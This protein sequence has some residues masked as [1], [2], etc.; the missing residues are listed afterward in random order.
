MAELSEGDGMLVVVLG[1]R[2]SD[3]GSDW[4]GELVV[5]SCREIGGEKGRVALG[6]GGFMCL[7]T[8]VTGHGT[9]SVK[10]LPES[11]GLFGTRQKWQPR[12]GNNMG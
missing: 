4:Y 6:I 5:R 12:V 8:S 3:V 2:M 9:D 10:A 7:S 1:R 11:N